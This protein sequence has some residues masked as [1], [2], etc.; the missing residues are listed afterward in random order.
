[1]AD[2]R[3]NYDRAERAYRALCAYWGNDG[4]ED[5]DMM[6]KDLIGDLHHLFDRIE[7]TDEEKAEG[8]DWPTLLDSADYMYQIEVTEDEP[9]EGDPFFSC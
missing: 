4:P 2:D 7:R 6:M 5:P 1:M 8:Y 9:G 3:T